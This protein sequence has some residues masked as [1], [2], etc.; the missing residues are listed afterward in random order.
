MLTSD[1]VEPITTLHW[2]STT[3]QPH[4]FLSLN[5]I[6]QTTTHKMKV[7]LTGATGF[8]G[9]EVLKQ[10]LVHPS[11][12][13]II[14]LGRR[15]TPL[16]QN[17]T[18]LQ[19]AKLKSAVCEEFTNYSQDVKNNCEGASAC[20]WYSPSPFQ[21]STQYKFTSSFK[22]GN[23]TNETQ[24]SRTNAHQSRRTPST[25]EKR[26]HPRLPRSLHQ[27]QSSIQR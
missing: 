9:A 24:G 1:P 19:A 14:S 7:I 27:D 25:E 10:A 22:D 5:S 12:T 11:I 26:N 23:H 18:P 3:H 8:L 6:L 21:H 4:P 13:S 20:I 2:P 16:P 17:T 15:H